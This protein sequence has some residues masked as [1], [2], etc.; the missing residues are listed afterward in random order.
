[1]ANPPRTMPILARP[2]LLEALLVRRSIGA[3]EAR[4]HECVH[5]HRTPLIGERIYLYDPA[6]RSSEPR[7]VCELCRPLRREEPA[8]SER[9]MPAEHA[10]TIRIE[11]AA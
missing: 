5:C 11:R 8:R 9:I 10:G 1:M 7:L 4:R 6:P 3:L 2:P